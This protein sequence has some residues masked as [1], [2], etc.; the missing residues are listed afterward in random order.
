MGYPCVLTLLLDLHATEVP[1]DAGP[2]CAGVHRWIG[3]S[4]GL[5]RNNKQGLSRDQHGK[6]RYLHDRRCELV[7]IQ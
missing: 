3:A 4:R 1:V 5:R 2:R 6:G 7:W